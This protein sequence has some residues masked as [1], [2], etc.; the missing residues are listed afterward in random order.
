[1]GRWGIPFVTT[2]I[3]ML[4]GMANVE[5]SVSGPHWQR[6]F[7]LYFP[8]MASYAERFVGETDAEDV[9]QCALTRLVNAIR[10]GKYERRPGAKFRSYLKMLIRREVAH[11]RRHERSRS[12][13]QRF[14]MDIEKLPAF[15]PDA[16]AEFDAQWRAAAGDA[17][18][19]HVLDET[20]LP[21]MMRRAYVEY[22][23]E[24]RPAGEVARELG[25][26]RGYVLQAKCRI[27]ARIRKV[28][29]MYEE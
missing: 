3:T 7:D 17:A 6:F 9:A 26:R 12:L 18:R 1:M 16:A 27:D 22:A 24:G 28:E 15:R 20:A 4:L 13:G 25:V 21:P 19:R 2:Q 23:V 14:E 8:A 11:W 29:A 10:R 5:E